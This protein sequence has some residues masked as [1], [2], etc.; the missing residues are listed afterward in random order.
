[1]IERVLVFSMDVFLCVVVYLMFLG[2]DNDL[3]FGLFSLLAYGVLQPIE[4]L[5]LIRRAKTLGKHFRLMNLV[6][7]SLS[8][9]CVVSAYVTLFRLESSLNASLFE[10]IVFIFPVCIAVYQQVNLTLQIISE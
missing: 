8:F 5:L 7:W 6:Y 2:S 1:M 4:S 9:L 10:F 3:Y